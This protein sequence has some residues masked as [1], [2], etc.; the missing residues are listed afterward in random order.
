MPG[1]RLGATH[2]PLGE[3]VYEAANAKVKR[4]MYAETQRERAE[5]LE[6]VRTSEWNTE[7]DPLV[8]SVQDGG[9]VEHDFKKGCVLVY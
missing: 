4:D 9:V 8:V 6:A 7:S 1:P 3:L 2:A 5:I